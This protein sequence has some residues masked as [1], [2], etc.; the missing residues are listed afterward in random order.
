MPWHDEESRIVLKNIGLI[1][2]LAGRDFQVLQV[3]I[4]DD[5]LPPPVSTELRPASIRPE[6]T[7]HWRREFREEG[8]WRTILE[9]MIDADDERAGEVKTG[10]REDNGV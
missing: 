10:V 4:V 6:I 3:L 1:N 8:V 9:A 7:A 5:G 2:V